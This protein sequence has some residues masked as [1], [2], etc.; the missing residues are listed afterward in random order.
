MSLCKCVK[1]KEKWLFGGCFH[2]FV[3]TMCS[4]VEIVPVLNIIL[5]V[6]MIVHCMSCILHFDKGKR[7]CPGASCPFYKRST[8]GTNSLCVGLSVVFTIFAIVSPFNKKI[9]VFFCKSIFTNKLTQDGLGFFS[10]PKKISQ[11]LV[12]ISV[13]S[14]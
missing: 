13:G 2:S 12:E 9:R 11:M 3:H 10:D 8:K 7:S 4:L 6:K 14:G 1:A 5:R